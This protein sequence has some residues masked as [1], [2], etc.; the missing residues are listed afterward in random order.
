M[1]ENNNNNQWWKPGV[2]IFSEVSGWI[3]GPIILAL[4][5]GKWLDGRFDTKPWIFL[6]L[7]GVAFLISIFGI[8]RIVS[9]Y[10]KNISKQ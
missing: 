1:S 3:A 8:V 9:R 7:T 6:G 4:I 5:A 10:M 2:K